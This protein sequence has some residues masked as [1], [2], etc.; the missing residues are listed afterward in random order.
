MTRKSNYK[1][2]ANSPNEGKTKEMRNTSQSEVSDPASTPVSA[3]STSSNIIPPVPPSFAAAVASG[4][5]ITTS[6]ITTPTGTITTTT[7]Q[8]QRNQYPDRSIFKTAQPSG[9]LRDEIVVSIDTIDGEQY[10]GTITVREA[11]REIFIGVLNFEKEVLASVS[12]GYNKGRI[13]TFKLVKEFDIDLLESVEIFSF[14]RQGQRKDGS[15]YEQV[16]GCKVRGIHRRTQ[17]TGYT[18]NPTRWVKIE[19]CE[20]RIEK[21]ELKTWLNHLGAVVSE[22]T[23]DRINLEEESDSDEE[24][25]DSFTVGTGIYSVKMRLSSPLPQ[26]VPMCGKRI[27]LY[28][29]DIPK[30]CTQCFG[31]HPRRGCTAEKVPWVR[32]VSEFMLR[33]NYIPDESYGKWAKIVA[34]W[35]ASGPQPTDQSTNPSTDETP[36]PGDEQQDDR[37]DQQATQLAHAVKLSQAGLAEGQKSSQIQSEPEQDQRRVVDQALVKLRA[38]GINASPVTRSKSPTNQANNETITRTESGSNNSNNLGVIDSN[39][40]NDYNY[41]TS[42]ASKVT[43]T[44]SGTQSKQKKKLADVN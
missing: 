28:Y 5:T 16:I 19:G 21:E 22:I 3:S 18:E 31:G 13:V 42:V 14:N 39:V 8:Q 1:R 27:R 20:Y 6:S 24:N 11:V 40:Y 23:E 30:I 33:Y 25:P 36:K 12:I 37:E 26:F 29:R 44:K 32:Y 34:D 17:P 35:R 9:G 43:A 4:L 38:L 10:N 15:L 41:N 7:S 2:P